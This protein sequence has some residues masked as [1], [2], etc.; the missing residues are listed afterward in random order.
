[1]TYAGERAL[2]L[3]ADDVVE[4]QFLPGTNAPLGLDH[5][6]DPALLVGVLER[7]AVRARVVDV[8]RVVSAVGAVDQWTV[9]QREQA[10]ELIVAILDGLAGSVSAPGVDADDGAF[11]E[12]APD[13]ASCGLIVD[14]VLPFERIKGALAY[15]EAGR[16]K[17]KVI[18]RPR[19]EAVS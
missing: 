6:D 10:G 15:L 11:G 12:I 7:D 8:S 16:A 18:L 1:V 2:I 9:R 3:V 19:D 4:K 14:Q 5:H 13:Q 17:G